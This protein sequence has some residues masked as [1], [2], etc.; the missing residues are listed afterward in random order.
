MPFSSICIG[1]SSEGVVEGVWLKGLRLVKT[2]VSTKGNGGEEEE[3]EEKGNRMRVILCSD[4][5]RLLRV[6]HGANV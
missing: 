2:G 3:E 1:D 5:V 6:R 4:K